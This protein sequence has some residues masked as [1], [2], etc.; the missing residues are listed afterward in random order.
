MVTADGQVQFTLQP[1]AT[2]PA[3]DV[4]MRRFGDRWVAE[5]GTSL[6]NV[7]IAGTPRE[8]LAAALAPLGANAVTRLL[9]DLNLLE[10]SCQVIE[11]GRVSSG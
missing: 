10:P 7:G 5:A 11:M 2:L 4:R 9:A 8:A 1:V 6:P 3:I